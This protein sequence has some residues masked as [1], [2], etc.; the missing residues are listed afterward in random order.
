MQC[1][2]AP[3]QAA[4]KAFTPAEPRTIRNIAVSLAARNNFYLEMGIRANQK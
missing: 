1:Y 3:V 4:K 2:W